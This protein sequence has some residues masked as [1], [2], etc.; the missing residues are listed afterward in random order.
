MI[1][2]T[3]RNISFNFYCNLIR[4]EPLLS[5]FYERENRLENVNN[6][7][8]LTKLLSGEIEFKR[9]S[10]STE[11]VYLSRKPK[12]FPTCGHCPNDMVNA[13]YSSTDFIHYKLRA[14]IL[15][16]YCL[17]SSP[18]FTIYW[19]LQSWASCLTSEL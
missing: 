16:T 2:Q 7:S 13:T 4:K 6:F 15:E 8:K 19:L 17:G 18:S 12:Y 9:S 10:Q 1:C 5:T 3:R 14:R 11:P